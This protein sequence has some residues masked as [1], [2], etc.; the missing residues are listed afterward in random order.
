MVEYKDSDQRPVNHRD[1]VEAARIVQR[2]AD[3]VSV[4]RK[5]NINDLPYF[6]SRALCDEVNRLQ[7]LSSR[8]L[9]KDPDE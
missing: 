6:V 3:I 2:A 1:A 9:P 5:E 4:Y 8:L 7:M